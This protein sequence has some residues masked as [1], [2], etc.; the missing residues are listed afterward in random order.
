MLPHVL[1]SVTPSNM[2]SGAPLYVVLNLFSQRKEGKKEGVAGVMFERVT[3]II[4]DLLRY[5]RNI[6]SSAL[7]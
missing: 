3:R 5:I 1:I 7:A 4:F 2:T 6:T